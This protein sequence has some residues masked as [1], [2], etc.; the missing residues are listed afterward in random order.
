MIR[1]QTLPGLY[2]STQ[3]AC[4]Y[5]PGR[6]AANLFVD[7]DV[8]LDTGLYTELASLGFRRS[9]DYLYR[10]QCPSCQACIP[11]RVPVSEFRPNRNQRRNLRQNATLSFSECPA[12]YRPEH[13]Q[14]YTR[15]LAR[16]HPG[17]GMDNPDPDSYQSF[18][19]S[20]WCKTRF[21]EIREARRLLAI[22]VVDHLD[23]ALSA[24]YTF[25]DPD[26][27]RRS[28]GRY[29]VLMEI[30]LARTLGLKWLYLGYWVSACRKMQYKD[31]FHPRQYF[32]QG[33]WQENLAPE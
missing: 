21:Y 20:N 31:E 30:R 14:L 4:H 16:R 27:T 15:Y 19:I 13:F 28:L 29:A 2:L 26:E 3:H 1:R 10:P 17:G 7:P 9:G 22:A 12:E 18:L 24:V 6:T 5:L 11:I 8:T 33:R 32:F 23:D 25:F